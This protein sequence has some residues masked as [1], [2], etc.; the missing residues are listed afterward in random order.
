MVD[1]KINDFD[2]VPKMF[3]PEMKVQLLHITPEVEGAQYV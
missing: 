2:S 3:T 1:N